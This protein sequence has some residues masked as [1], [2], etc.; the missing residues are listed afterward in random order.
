MSVAVLEVAGFGL[1]GG[2]V[3]S[4]GADEVMLAVRVEGKK[5]ARS[6]YVVSLSRIR[7]CSWVNDVAAS[8]VP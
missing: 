1:A 3:A 7:Q 2:R 4:I 5:H 6:L 8:Y